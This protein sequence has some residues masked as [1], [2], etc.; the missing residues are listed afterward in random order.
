MNEKAFVHLRLAES[1]ARSGHFGG[2][3]LAGVQAAES[4]GDIRGELATRPGRV[5]RFNLQHCCSS[6][7]M[8]ACE[9]LFRETV[10][11]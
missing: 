11:V 9:G 4:P 6:A 2:G 3:I 10:C 1:L 5:A 7:G 8:G